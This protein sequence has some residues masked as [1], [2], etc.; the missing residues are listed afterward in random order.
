MEQDH[1]INFLRLKLHN[2]RDFICGYFNITKQQVRFMISDLL[3][4]PESQCHISKLNY[5]EICSCFEFIRHITLGAR[6]GKGRRLPKTVTKFKQY[7][8][9]LR[10]EQNNG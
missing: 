3:D 9:Q 4:K 7:G 1:N 2:E 5:E 8:I 6:N 10:E